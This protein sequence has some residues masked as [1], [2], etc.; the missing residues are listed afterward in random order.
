MQC[1]VWA[2]NPTF[3]CK[4]IIEQL[5]HKSPFHDEPLQ[6]D[7]CSSAPDFLHLFLPC[8]AHHSLVERHQSLQ[9]HQQWGEECRWFWKVCLMMKK[10]NFKN[11]SKTC[12][13]LIGIISHRREKLTAFLLSLFVG[14]LGVD[15]FYLRQFLLLWQLSFRPVGHL[16]A[17]LS[18]SMPTNVL[19]LGSDLYI[20]AGIIKLLLVGSITC[21]CSCDICGIK[22]RWNPGGA[23]FMFARRHWVASSGVS[24]AWPPSPGGWST[25]PGESS[26]SRP[27]SPSQ[28]NSSWHSLQDPDRQLPW[29]RG[30]Q[31][32]SLVKS[33]AQ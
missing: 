14:G 24:L 20:L 12:C 5:E 15:W 26:P 6:E 10:L 16:S 25:G 18:N 32:P 23:T 33:M 19:S 1:I 22:V 17:T 21:C 31:S 11:L 29:W 27:P 4:Q 2:G 28:A 7:V 9:Q 30:S 8:L 3:Q 13:V